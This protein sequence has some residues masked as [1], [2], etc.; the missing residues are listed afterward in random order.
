M[1]RIFLCTVTRRGS[2]LP[3]VSGT[4]E[5]WT[6][7]Q[8]SQNPGWAQ[9]STHP[10]HSLCTLLQQHE[11]PVQGRGAL[12]GAVPCEICGVRGAGGSTPALVFPS[13]L[14]AADTSQQVD[15]FNSWGN[16]GAG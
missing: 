5:G 6:P 13:P 8:L 7:G 9:E 14:E 4:G 16:T 11:Q 2:S 15:V 1:Q 3:E 10:E 12:I